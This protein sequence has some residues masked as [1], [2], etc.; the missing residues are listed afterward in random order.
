MRPHGVTDGLAKLRA[1]GGSRQPAA[2]YRIIHLRL[3]K[4][5][6]FSKHMLPQNS[7]S[8]TTVSIDSRSSSSSSISTDFCLRVTTR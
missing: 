1:T 7:C 6:M 3:L 5:L 8:S 4:A 2:F